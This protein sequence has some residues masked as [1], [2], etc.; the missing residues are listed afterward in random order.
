MS[1]KRKPITSALVSTTTSVNII[2]G[3][4]KSNVVPT[5]VRTTVNHRIAPYHTINDVLNHITKITSNFPNVTVR[6]LEQLPPSPISD[7]NSESYK[8]LSSAILKVFPD[9][10]VAPSLMIGNTDTRW[11]WNVSKNIFRFSP[12]HMHGHEDVARFHGTNERINV[13]DYVK[14]IDFYYHAI[15]DSTSLPSMP[16]DKLKHEL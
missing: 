1:L 6:V 10:V 11:F 14:V 15:R 4:F 12:I 16:S 2:S 13:K 5:N 3:G 8:F 7:P 9:V